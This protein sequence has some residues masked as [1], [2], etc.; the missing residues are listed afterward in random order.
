MKK[1]NLIY[2]TLLTLIFISCN[3]LRKE[4]KTLEKATI[5]FISEN[6][7]AI[8]LNGVINSSALENF[9]A[10]N[11]QYPNI[12]ALKIINCDGSINDDI[13]LQLAKYIHQQNFNIHLNE[14]GLIASG[15]TD[16]FLSGKKRTVGK[17]T[18]IGVHSW[19]DGKNV[20]ATD[21]PEGHKN[22][23]PYIDYY[24][25]IGFIDKQA[26][27]FYYFT[28]NSAPVDDIHWMTDEEIKKYQIINN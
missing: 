6:Q 11:N 14:N 9:K 12:R 24:K 1:I 3:P 2:L 5:F 16:L 20:K 8:I 25:S 26:K 28:I 13:N 22:H 19:G 27:D 4:F 15:G 7:D 17:N 23:Q 18:K 21:F 10:L